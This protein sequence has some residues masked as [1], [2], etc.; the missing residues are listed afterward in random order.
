VIPSAALRETFADIDIYLFDQLLRGRLDDRRRVLDAGCG[1]GRNLHYLL[2]AGFDCF[3]VDDDARAI[4]QL[5]QRAAR[6]APRVPLSQFVVGEIGALPFEDGSMDVVICSAVLHFA[7]DAPHFGL[8]LTDLWRVVAPG[9]M[10]FTRLASNIGLERL[11]GDRAGRRLRL[12]DG[13]D[14]FVVDE[15]ILV[16]WTA[17]L[18]ARLLDPIK[19]TNV[20]QQRC[21]TTWILG[22]SR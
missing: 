8:M 13:T 1:D 9:G 11:I 15:A 17:R 6:V 3:G 14:R 20:Q 12:P 2:G 22:R 4:D 10:L 18:G 5:R 19:T 7:A 21:M 16:D